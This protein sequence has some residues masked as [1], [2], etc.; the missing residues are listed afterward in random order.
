MPN[1][2]FKT[3]AVIWSDYDPRTVELSDLA[4][5]AESG[6]SFCSGTAVVEVEDPANDPDFDGGEFLCEMAGIDLDDE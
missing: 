2:L 3:T 5:D 6:D 4:R 1:K